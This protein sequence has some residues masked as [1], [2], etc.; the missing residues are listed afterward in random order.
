MFLKRTDEETNKRRRIRTNPFHVMNKHKIRHV[1]Y[2]DTLRKE[3]SIESN[4]EQSFVVK[5]YSTLSVIIYNVAI[6]FSNLP[7][8]IIM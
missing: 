6:S 7:L 2:N 1:P 5:H 4:K 8:H 3:T